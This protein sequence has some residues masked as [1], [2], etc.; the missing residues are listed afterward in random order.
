M[1]GET[2]QQKLVLGVEV[3]HR[4]HR[5]AGG[6]ES[7]ERNRN[8]LG[9]AETDIAQLVQFHHQRVDGRIS[10]G[11]IDGVD[12]IPQQH[13]MALGGG[14]GEQRLQRLHLRLLVDDSAGE[15]EQ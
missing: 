3:A 5:L 10:R 12:D 9:L 6:L 11:K 7:L 13:F 1:V 8:F 14:L 2:R 15:I 4:H